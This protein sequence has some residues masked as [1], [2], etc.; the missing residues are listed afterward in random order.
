MWS[1]GECGKKTTGLQK[2]AARNSNRSFQQTNN[3]HDYWSRH[4]NMLRALRKASSL[5][6]VFQ[7]KKNQDKLSWHEFEVETVRIELTTFRM[8]SGRA[9]N[10]AILNLIVSDSLGTI[11]MYATHSPSLESRSSFNIYKSGA[12]C[13]I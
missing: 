12:M 9:T 3:D 8:Q 4:G 10:C 13:Q 5:A 1:N 6:L 7:Q 11:R 2:N